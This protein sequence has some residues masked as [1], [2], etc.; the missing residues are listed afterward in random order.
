MRDIPSRTTRSNAIF[1]MRIYIRKQFRDIRTNTNVGKAL[2]RFVEH[3]ESNPGS[4]HMLDGLMTPTIASAKRGKKRKGDD[5]D[6][7]YRP[8]PIRSIGSAP[9]TRGRRVN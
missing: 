1:D 4:T 9:K 6:S 7:E 3:A 2:W 8:A 5:E